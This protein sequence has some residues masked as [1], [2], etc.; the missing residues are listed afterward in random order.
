MYMTTD[1]RSKEK[2]KV[3]NTLFSHVTN[4]I[5]ASKESKVGHKPARFMHTQVN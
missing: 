2:V 3:E 1:R 5:A 4:V